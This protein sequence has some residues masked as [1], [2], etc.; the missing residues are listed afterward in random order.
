MVLDAAPTPTE[1]GRVSVDVTTSPPPARF[2]IAAYWLRS[3]ERM[4]AGAITEGVAE[5]AIYQAVVDAI[6]EAQMNGDRP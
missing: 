1:G 6:Q 4:V 5:D 2:S 3:I